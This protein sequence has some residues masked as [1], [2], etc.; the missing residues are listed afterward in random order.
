MELRSWARATAT[1]A[2]A[3]RINFMFAVLEMGKQI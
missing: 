1:R 2:E 3:A